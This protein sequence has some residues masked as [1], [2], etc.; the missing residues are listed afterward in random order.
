MKLNNKIISI[1]KDQKGAVA[2]IVGL[3]L[4]FFIVGFAALAIDVG[5]LYATRSELQNIVDSAALAAAGEL[6]DQY[7][8]GEAIDIGEIKGVAVDAGSKNRAADKLGIII[9][10]DDIEI[11]NW[12]SAAVP[13]FD[14]SSVLT[15]DEDAV[16]VRARRQK[17]ES[18]SA[19]G[20]V[21]T[22]FANIFG[23]PTADLQANA[24]A[25]L[26]GPSHIPT[27]GLPIPV[28]IGEARFDS[29]FCDQP[30]KFYPT[31]DL[32][33]CG[34]WHVFEDSKTKIKQDIL[35]EMIP[36][37]DPGWESPYTEAGVEFYFKGGTDT[38]GWFMLKDIFD[39]R[40]GVND[41]LDENG[42]IKEWPIDG[43]L[44]PETW[45]TTVVVYEELDGDCSNPVNYLK[46]IGFAAIRVYEVCTSTSDTSIPITGGGVEYPPLPAY[47]PS[48]QEYCVS[49]Q[50][51]LVA[52]IACDFTKLQRG[53]GG[54]FGIMGVIPGLVE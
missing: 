14:A 12:D 36:W 15:G 19:D 46:I 48:P 11:G 34:G 31:H 6:G 1:I 50:K 37:D 25:A 8:N 17:N 38:A 27:G 18:K 54:E 13:P 23:F 2:V 49:G 40:K 42:E 43:D 33:A 16:R 29:D 45:S 10:P 53:G 35:S 20:A 47:P 21:G 41:Y 28:G 52:T 9:D 22:F 7:F 3:A 5:Y 30:L 39:D 32:E 51:Q 26:S 24:T 44:D 4:F